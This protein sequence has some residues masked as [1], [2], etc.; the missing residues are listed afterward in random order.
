MNKLSLTSIA[1]CKC[2]VDTRWTCIPICKKRKNNNK[3]GGLASWFSK[4][5]KRDKK[6]AHRARVNK[7]AVVSV[8]ELWLT[9]CVKGKWTRK[10]KTTE[11]GFSN[12]RQRQAIRRKHLLEQPRDYSSVLR[13]VEV[14][15]SFF[16]YS[17]SHLTI[18]PF[19][20]CRQC[21]ISISLSPSLFL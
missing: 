7:Q 17:S 1:P 2:S 11:N 5:K 4:P 14:A 15:R 13:G 16:L 3:K 20:R 18:F 19:C 21:V 6:K 10:K 9:P 8:I 12:I